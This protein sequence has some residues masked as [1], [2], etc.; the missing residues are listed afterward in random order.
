MGAHPRL[1]DPL[2]RGPIVVLFNDDHRLQRMLDF[3]AAL[4]RAE[5][6]AGVIPAAPP[7]CSVKSLP[8]ISRMRVKCLATASSHPAALSP[9]VVGSAC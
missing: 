4:S 2:F 1:L 8:R 3:E 7:N 6:K 5:A 9:N